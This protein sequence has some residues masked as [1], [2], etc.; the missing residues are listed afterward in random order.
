MCPMLLFVFG[1]LCKRF[2]KIII[3]HLSMSKMHYQG[4]F[5][6][7]EESRFG[8]DFLKKCLVDINSSEDIGM[9]K[10]Q[11]QRELNFLEMFPTGTEYSRLSG[12]EVAIYDCISNKIFSIDLCAEVRK[13]CEDESGKNEILGKLTTDLGD[14]TIVEG[15]R[16]RKSNYHG[17]SDR[18]LI[19][20]DY[21]EIYFDSSS[22]KKKGEFGYSFG[23]KKDS[24]ISGGLKEIHIRNYVLINEKKI[25]ESTEI[26][27][28]VV[29]KGRNN[30][31]GSKILKY[32]KK[33][34]IYDLFSIDKV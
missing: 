18:R 1:E 24:I 2:I 32:S 13:I 33:K 23:I 20:N 22:Y 16:I 5:Y 3:I 11:I 15:V 19:P 4:F 6:P 12:H 34:D 17:E 9:T 21:L 26:A 30:C 7:K 10:S 8:F 25:Y 27:K 31:I 28:V 29:I 14:G